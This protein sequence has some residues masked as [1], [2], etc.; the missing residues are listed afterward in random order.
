[1]INKNI[2]N[3]SFFAKIINKNGHFHQKISR[4]LVFLRCTKEQSF[5]TNPN[6]I[7][8]ISLQPLTFQT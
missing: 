5:T 7:I 4:S 2:E 1:M 3:K 8:P 6:F